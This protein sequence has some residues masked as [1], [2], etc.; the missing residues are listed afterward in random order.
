MSAERLSP[1]DPNSFS[2]PDE[3]KVTH[4]DLELDIDF[5]TKTLSGHVVLSVEKVNAEANTLILDSRDL[6]VSMVQDFESKQLLKYE[7]GSSST[8]FGEKLEIHFLKS[9]KA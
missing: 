8:T 6:T 7:L 5:D 9:N 4:M 1:G 3:V 2:R